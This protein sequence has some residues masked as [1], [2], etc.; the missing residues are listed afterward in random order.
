MFKE[1][2]NFPQKLRPE[3]FRIEMIDFERQHFIDN[4]VTVNVPDLPFSFRKFTNESVKT[5][6]LSP[7]LPG[8]KNNEK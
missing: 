5:L 6:P 8:T 1:L 7:P 2:H 4:P 3:V